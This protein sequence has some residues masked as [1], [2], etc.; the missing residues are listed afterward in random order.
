MHLFIKT[1]GCGMIKPR[2]LKVFLCHSSADKPTVRDLYKRLEKCNI[3]PWLDEKNLLPGQNWEY[4]IRKAVRATD[5]VIVCLSSGSVNKIGFV[6][7][8]IKFALDVADEQPEGTIF[9]IPLKLEECEIPERLRHLHWVNYGEGAGFYRLMSA[10]LFKA[11]S[12]GEKLIPIT[13]PK[14]EVIEELNKVAEED[15]KHDQKATSEIFSQ[16]QYTQTWSVLQPGYLIFLLDQSYS[17]SETIGEVQIVRGGK[18]RCDMVA[19]VLNGFI[20]ELIAT[21]V[22]IKS[23]GTPEVRPL[24]ELTVLGYS[25]RTVRSLLS[26]GLLAN[27]IVSTLPVLAENPIDI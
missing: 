27:K 6:Q 16:N 4:E 15:L 11:D 10:L 23:D 9:L 18:R 24:V 14:E 1:Q 13:L 17:M 5:I 26:S 7:K 2:R 25:S 22:R 12:F 21:S 20:N 3:D 19:N 8:E